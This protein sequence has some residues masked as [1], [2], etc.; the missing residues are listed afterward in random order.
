MKKFRFGAE[1]LVK[2][3]LKIRV[4][5]IWKHYSDFRKRRKNFLKK[6]FFGSNFFFD[7]FVGFRRNS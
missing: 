5:S 3:I 1:L 4:L 2:K 7:F 6:I